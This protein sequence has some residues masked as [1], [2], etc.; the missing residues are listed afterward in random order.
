MAQYIWYGLWLF[1]PWATIEHHIKLES[2]TTDKTGLDDFFK[3]YS[4]Y[5][6]KPISY[7]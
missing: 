3:A 2:L 1:E 4:S 7:S 6:F 5:I